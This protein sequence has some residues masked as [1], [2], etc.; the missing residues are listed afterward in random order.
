MNILFVDLYNF[1]YNFTYSSKFFKDSIEFYRKSQKR[2]ESLKNS[3]K[4]KK[5]AK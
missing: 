5:K 3:R 1:I 4:Y 2:N